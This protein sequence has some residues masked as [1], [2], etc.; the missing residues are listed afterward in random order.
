MECP[1]GNRLVE[2][3]MGMG[4]GVGVG[5][6]TGLCLPFLRGPRGRAGG[7]KGWE[8]ASLGGREGGRKGS[9]MVLYC[10]AV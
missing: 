8:H 4:V 9:T 7:V 3:G 1:Y 10:T 2:V 5:M 6:G